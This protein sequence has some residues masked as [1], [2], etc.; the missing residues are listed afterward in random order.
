MSRNSRENRTGLYG[1]RLDSRSRNYRPG[2]RADSKIPIGYY[3]SGDSYQTEDSVNADN[4][5]DQQLKVDLDYDGR[6][7][8]E[9]YK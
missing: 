6:L 7:V 4:P 1:R 2:A 3:R 9:K 5:V 8:T